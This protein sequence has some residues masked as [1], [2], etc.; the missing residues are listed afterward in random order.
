MDHQTTATITTAYHMYINLLLL[1][2]IAWYHIC[3]GILTPIGL[4]FRR[5]YLIRHPN[6]T[7]P[8]LIGSTHDPTIHSFFPSS[9]LLREFNIP[10]APPLRRWCK[11]EE[12]RQRV[13]GEVPDSSGIVLQ[14]N[15]SGL[16]LRQGQIIIQQ[17]AR[18][19]IGEEIGRWPDREDYLL[20]ISIDLNTRRT[21]SLFIPVDLFDRSYVCDDAPRSPLRTPF[22]LAEAIRISRHL[23][24]TP[25]A[26]SPV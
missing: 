11:P 8:T 26:L 4:V 14:G 12:I 22:S 15:V 9:T 20:T 16:P 23:Q 18:V 2:T 19:Y 3:R 17:E 1:F 7:F 24:H 25:P 21:F 10:N 6:Q 13:I 5:S